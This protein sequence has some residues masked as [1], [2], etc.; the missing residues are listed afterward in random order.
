MRV[1]DQSF[2]DGFLQLV[3]IDRLIQSDMKVRNIFNSASKCH[4]VV[5]VK[6]IERTSVILIHLV[7]PH[8]IM[9]SF[10]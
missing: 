7:S 4:D 9:Y 6:G 1:L 3:R 2:S 10:S 5:I 8:S